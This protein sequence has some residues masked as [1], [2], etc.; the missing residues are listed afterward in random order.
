MRS[1]IYVCSFMLLIMLSSVVIMA[2]CSQTVYAHLGW[3]LLYWQDNSDYSSSSLSSGLNTG[4]CTETR[5]QFSPSPQYYDFRNFFSLLIFW[6]ES[7]QFES[8]NKSII[9]TQFWITFKWVRNC[10]EIPK[11]SVQKYPKERGTS[12]VISRL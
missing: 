3:P 11:T 1:K 6:L 10:L 9:L 12:I 5:W 2:G 7:L 4:L 8:V